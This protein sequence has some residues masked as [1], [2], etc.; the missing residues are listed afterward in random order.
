MLG[1]GSESPPRL[2]LLQ[3]T[4]M[5]QVAFNPAAIPVNASTQDFLPKQPVLPGMQQVRVEAQ[6]PVRGETGSAQLMSTAASVPSSATRAPSST[7]GAVEPSPARLRRAAAAQSS[8]SATAEAEVERDAP[9]PSQK[10]AKHGPAEGA[11]EDATEDEM[12]VKTARAPT[13]SVEPRGVPERLQRQSAMDAMCLAWSPLLCHATSTSGQAPAQF[14][15]L[16]VGLK[17]GAVALWRF[18]LPSRFNPSGISSERQAATLIG[19]LPAHNSWVTAVAWTACKPRASE[20]SSAAGGSVWLATGSCDGSVRLW[21]QTWDAL[22]GEVT[23]MPVL[24]LRSE[25][26]G[27]DSSGV[28]VLS[29]VHASCEQLWLAAGK[30]AGDLLVWR[31]DGVRSAGEAAVRGV[32]T[33]VTAAHTQSI[34][35]VAWGADRDRRWLITN[36]AD[37]VTQ[38]WMLGTT[39]ASETDVVRSGGRTLLSPYLVRLDTLFPRRPVFTR[40]ALR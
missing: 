32:R 21:W 40:L 14:A 19:L 16:A 35:G 4:A 37:C 9:Q 38:N 18:A 23:R 34:M 13:A 8:P 26:C 36:S 10:R 11:D 33:R 25:I 17:S 27:P 39:A 3:G 31:G 2:V 29:M 12:E 15:L 7:S 20:N 24:V 6:M 30:G 1:Q 22:A 5:E 28:H